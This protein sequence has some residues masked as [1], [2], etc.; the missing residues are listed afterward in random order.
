MKVFLTGAT[1]Y[2]GGAV[3]TALQNA[4]HDVTA[5]IRK[6]ESADGLP[7]VR[8]VLGDL[9]DHDWLTAQLTEVDA[10]VHAASPNDASS[11]ALDGAVLDAVLPAFAGTD[12]PY[13]HTAGSWIH[14]SGTS[15]TEDSPFNPPPI[16]G[17]RPAVVERVRAAD[18][19]TVVISPA[20]LYGHGGGLTA[21]LVHGPVVDDALSFPGGA[22]H[23]NSVHVDDAA[24]LYQ[25]ALESAP[26]GSYYLAA[27]V[28]PPL[29]SEVAAA[30]SRLR[31][32]DGRIVAEPESSTRDRLG[33]IA[34]PLLLDQ[35]VDISHAAELG[36]APTGPSLLEE[37]GPSGSYRAS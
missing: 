3:L 15:I 35:R 1:G 17:W 21:L 27:T 10:A 7:G 34:D 23:F 28:D 25:L 20:N 2:L 11:A 8:T 26:G 14:G 32:L 5:H 24:R 16:V 12:R 22:Q 18:A 36:W 29:I 9:P 33:P 31:G 30:A 4:G 13:V 37:L 6:P 19:H